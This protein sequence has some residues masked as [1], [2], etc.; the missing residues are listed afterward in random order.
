MST[1]FSDE[2]FFFCYS[3]TMLAQPDTICP[4]QDFLKP[5]TVKYI[6]AC[7][8][9]G[10]LDKLPPTPIV[11]KDDQG[12]LIAIDGHNLIAVKLQRGEAVDVHLALSA[13]DGLPTGSEATIARNTDL[14]EKF[15]TV[16]ED[17]KRIQES[18]IRSFSD[19]VARYEDLFRH[20]S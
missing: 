3:Y 19:L 2:V 12:N 14:K 20:V 1:D 17:S 10:E 16:I 18:G 15:E 5:G 7:I 11:R 13:D 8:N 4:S 6:F 9:A